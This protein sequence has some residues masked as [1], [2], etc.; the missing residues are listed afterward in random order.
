MSLFLSWELFYDKLPKNGDKWQLEA[1]RWTRSGGFSF[2][3]SESVHN[4]SSWGDIVFSGLTRENLN[5]IKRA[6]VFQAVNKYRSAKKINALAGQWED[7][8]LGDSAFFEAKVKPLFARLDG[9]AAQVN[10][11]MTAADVET[12]FKEAVPDWMELNFRVAALR[13]QYLKNKQL[14]TS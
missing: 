12:L 13:A 6:I 9:Y 5:E 4:R 11:E 10:K 1:I 14:G 2:G 7:S 8:E 3:G